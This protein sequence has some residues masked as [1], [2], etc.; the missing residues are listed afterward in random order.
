MF[1]EINSPLY[2]IRVS[3]CGWVSPPLRFRSFSPPSWKLPPP[4][5]RLLSLCG[6]SFSHFQLFEPSISIEFLPYPTFNLY[7]IFSSLRQQPL[8]T[9]SCKSKS[10]FTSQ[11]AKASEHPT[12]KKISTTRSFKIVEILC[13]DTCYC[14]FVYHFL[15]LFVWF[16]CV[17]LFCLA[18]FKCV[19]KVFDKRLQRDFDECNV[20]LSKNLSMSFA[21]QT[22]SSFQQML[23]SEM[24]NLINLKNLYNRTERDKVK[25]MICNWIEKIVVPKLIY[26]LWKSLLGCLD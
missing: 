21:N 25:E 20:F 16:T 14:Y 15:C 18:C 6:F 11:Y 9:H 13:L 7:H 23:L 4:Q 12:W 5:W 24:M 17:L 2:K 10:I 3:F 19:F 1:R 22:L 8:G 26:L